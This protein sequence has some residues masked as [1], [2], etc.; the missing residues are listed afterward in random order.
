MQNSMM[1]TMVEIAAREKI[2]NK[3]FVA[4]FKKGK[5]RKC[6]KKCGLEGL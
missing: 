2:K 6:I 3:D 1:V 4:K 5:G